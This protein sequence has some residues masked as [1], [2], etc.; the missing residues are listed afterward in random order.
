M[1]QLIIM[2]RLLKEIKQDVLESRG[3]DGLLPSCLEKALLEKVPF[4]LRTA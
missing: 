1:R 3:R 4:Y 2:V